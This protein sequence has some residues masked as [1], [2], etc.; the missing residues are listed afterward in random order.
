MAALLPPS[1]FFFH[2]PN[3]LLDPAKVQ[4]ARSYGAALLGD[5]MRPG[6]AD[7]VLLH[8]S[9]AYAL[10]IKRPG[11]GLSPEQERIHARLLAAD[12]PCAVVFSPDGA[13]LA[14]RAW[15]LPLAGGA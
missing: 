12:I 6:M 4:D 1:A 7:I 15:N 10:E 5:G 9:K 11:G 3:Q 14:L 8:A 2:C 13:E